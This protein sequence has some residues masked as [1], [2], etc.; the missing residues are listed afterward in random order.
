MSGFVVWF[1]GLSAAG[2]T[3]RN[4]SVVWLWLGGGPTQTCLVPPPPK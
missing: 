4:T 3:T 1:T 2:K